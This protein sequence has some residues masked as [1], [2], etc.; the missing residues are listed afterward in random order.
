[1]RFLLPLLLLA[2]SG[3]LGQRWLDRRHEWRALQNAATVAAAPGAVV[4]AAPAWLSEE[5]GRLPA[6]PDL[7][8]LRTSLQG[9]GPPDALEGW[10]HLAG[11]GGAAAALELARWLELQPSA[12]RAEALAIRPGVAD[13]ATDLRVDVA[14][15]A[16]AILP[17]V[18]HLIGGGP[19][20]GYWTDPR[21]VHLSWDGS[22]GLRAVVVLRVEALEN[23]VPAVAPA[24]DAGAPGGGS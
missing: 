13:G 16:R 2:A 20:A 24:P 3:L 10:E 8:A 9:W 15:P 4:A 6:A 11:T 21:R 12:G 5:F 7:E 18:A 23:L 1:M 19:T 17:W 22:A 14:G